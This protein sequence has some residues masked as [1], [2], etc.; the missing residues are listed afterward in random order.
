MIKISAALL[1][2]LACVTGAAGSAWAQE[3]KMVSSWDDRYL[4]TKVIADAFTHEVNKATGGKVTIKRSGPEVV[5]VMQQLQPVSVGVFQLLF[6]HGGY[7]AGA[8]GIALAL[9]A[10]DLDAQKR[11]DSG[12]WDFVD[13][14]YRKHNL[15]VIALP[16]AGSSGY[17]YFLRKPVADGFKGMKIRGTP[18]YHRMVTTLGGTPVVLPPTEIYTSLEKGVVDGAGWALIGGLDYKWYEVAKYITRPS[19]G[20]STHL[21]L[22]NRTAWD[23]LD[24]P[25]QKIFLDIGRKLEA[26]SVKNYDG[27][28]AAEI[29]ELKKRGVQETDLGRSKEEI[30]KLWAEGVWQVALSGP[31]KEDAEKMR[32]LAIEKGLSK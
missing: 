2:G 16:V 18:L 19:F 1:L 28:I 9:D 3:L 5:P 14:H 17:H 6:S 27:L 21:I 30:E 13:A 32:K 29:A 8:T 25:T 12:L 22:M 20:V 15:K 7:H 24:A 26:E 11:R 23:K 31:A 10:V 4:G